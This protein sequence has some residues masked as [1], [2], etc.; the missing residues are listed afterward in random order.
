M[1]EHE[2]TEPRN[3]FP[4]GETIPQ[5]PLGIKNPLLP[6]NPLGQSLLNPKFLHPLGARSI[7]VFNPSGFFSEEVADE[8][9]PDNPF[10][11]SPFF[12]ESQGS[13][14]SESV[15][16]DT[17]P[18]SAEAALPVM[19]ATDPTLVQPVLATEPPAKAV[20]IGP[21]RTP[22]AAPATEI[23]NAI[24][25]SPS[26]STIEPPIA[27]LTAPLEAAGIEISNAI[28]SSPSPSTIQ[29]VAAIEASTPGVT[30]TTERSNDSASS[31]SPSTI[32]PPIAALTALVE[33]AGTEISNAIASSP[34]SSTIQKAPAIDEQTT[35]IE[36]L[37]TEISNAIASSP[38]PSTIQR[39]VT[40][41]ASTAPDST[42]ATIAAP[43]TEISN[44]SASSP[45]PNTIQPPID[46]LTAPLEAAG[47]EIS[48]EIANSP[49][50]STIQRAAAIEASTPGVTPTTERSNDSANS[51]SP[52]T[53]Q[54]AATIDE[55]TA[56]LEAA[57]TEI[58]NE[59]AYS[60]SPSTIQRAAA[61]DE[62]STPGV[63]P[64]TEISNQSANSSSSSPIQ[65]TAEI[66]ASTPDVTP[67]TERSNAIANSP[68][69]STIPL[70]ATGTEISNEIANSPSASTIQGAAAIDEQTAPI[71]SPGTEITNQGTSSPSPST[72]Q[73]AAEI[74]EQ[75]APIESPGTEINNEIASWPSSS[76]IQSPIDALTAP[77]EAAGIKISNQSASSPSSS[78][79][80]RVE[81]IEASTPGVTPTTERSNAIASSPSASI[82]QRT[83]AIEV[84]TEPD[85]ALGTERSNEISLPSSTTPSSVPTKTAA[86][87]AR[88]G[89]A[90]LDTEP[91]VQKAPAINEQIAPNVASA[92]RDTIASQRDPIDSQ[93]T[94]GQT[95]SHTEPQVQRAPAVEE[96]TSSITAPAPEQMTPV[97]NPLADS[98]SPT[99]PS[100]VQPDTAAIAPT[101]EQP[102]LQA[103]LQV[104][105][106]QM[107]LLTAPQA[108]SVPP[109]TE[110]EL[111]SAVNENLAAVSNL[112]TSEA[113]PEVTTD[114][115]VVQPLSETKAANH[116]ETTLSKVTESIESPMSFSGMTEAESV[117][118]PA[119][120][121]ENI[122]VDR[123][124]ST[125][126][127]TKVESLVQK[128]PALSTA[129]EPGEPPLVQRMEEN[130][131]SEVTDNFAPTPSLSTP[132]TAPPETTPNIS[133]LVQASLNS[134]PSDSTSPVSDVLEPF[135]PA[136]QLRAEFPSQVSSSPPIPT[137]AIAP[138]S[139]REETT[140]TESTL[141]QPIG[142]LSI[143]TKGEVLPEFLAPIAELPLPI[144]SSV[145]EP[146]AFNLA[147]SPTESTD[148]P[149]QTP[150]STPIIGDTV[151]QPKLETVS[152][153]ED[154]TRLAPKAIASTDSRQVPE[155][156]T[157]PDATVIQPKLEPEPVSGNLAGLAPDAIASTD[158]RQVP[159]STTTPD[160]TVIQPKLEPEPVSEN[161]AGLAPNAIAFT[162][163]I[164]VPESTT[165]PDAT[166]IQPKLETEPAS[167]DFPVDT[168]QGI[169]STDSRQVPESITTPDA[170]VIQPKLATELVSEKVTG[171][172]PAAIAFT[173]SIQVPESTTTPDA[174]LIQPKLETEPARENLAG[175]AQDAIASTSFANP[176]VEVPQSTQI[177]EPTVIQP[178]VETE[179]LDESEELPQLPQVLTNLSILS[180][181]AQ[182][183]SLLASPFPDMGSNKVEESFLAPLSSNFS[184]ASEPPIPIQRMPEDSGQNNQEA[185]AF[186][187]SVEQVQMAPFSFSSSPETLPSSNSSTNTRE[188]P[189][190]WSSISELIGENTPKASESIVVQ[191]LSEQRTWEAPQKPIISKPSDSNSSQSNVSHPL[192]NSPQNNSLGN[193]I[194]TYSMPSRRTSASGMEALIQL[195]GDTDSQVGA[196]DQSV[197]TVDDFSSE[198]ATDNLELLAREVY[199]F[200]RQRLEIERERRGN[201]YSGRLPW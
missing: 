143:Q 71:E 66:E 54:R 33:A 13:K 15:D 178:L 192:M 195:M 74:D 87:E 44:E 64:T 52:S 94:L 93:P 188:I 55:Q 158:S 16:V 92:P 12:A 131:S 189:T 73:R 27:A 79:I 17:A 78:T 184:S 128:A 59:I 182:Q 129:T 14:S 140:P 165:T 49:S 62:A 123:S 75:T 7:T 171:L 176:P 11:N 168:K 10:K 34:F 51:P 150:E 172:A 5:E 112:T 26:P 136:V 83:V 159:E 91:Q 147:L 173:D 110:L 2:G 120:A 135:E 30:P 105:K 133:T 95:L 124:D 72:I 142:E 20:G 186:S 119:I 193:V 198:E 70:E 116:T 179:S 101:V 139:V 107:P 50:P 108:A 115:V 31:P 114:R 199:S 19:R 8:F 134:Q 76:T 130:F 9:P 126:P 167:E 98:S 32:E 127:V 162:D 99:M 200:I 45:S 86:T 183:S 4:D 141:I 69:A 48:N 155:S 174:T 90:F 185:T 56:P 118:M 122:T 138:K 53:I 25:S 67:T 96:F 60:P 181:L 103:E 36:S 35:P 196:I 65:R 175:L 194:Q 164:Q 82:I 29:R 144:E 100:S 166:L 18:I 137:S 22:I 41:E 109:E 148:S 152:A 191:P 37:G 3:N 6:P 39:A 21:I 163:S 104:Q 121:S 113:V 201:N 170:T 80:Q 132:A 187:S 46:A 42:P 84:A 57:G 106:V 169:A 43:R 89:Q 68:S 61:I 160:A 151:I 40:I 47:T 145:K 24:A 58:S 197:S 190:S 154:L 177:T 149:L 161:L 156:T 23:S 102:L 28:A 146:E 157:T 97:K 81:A 180:P 125:A 38:S 88:L 117:E 1:A 63:T 85:A 77:L 153:S 111:T